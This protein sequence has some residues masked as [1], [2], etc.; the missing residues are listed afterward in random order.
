M[1]SFVSWDKPEAHQE[2]DQ[3]KLLINPQTKMLEY[4]MYTIRETYLNMPGA[5]AFF[6]SI[7]FSDFK[8]INGVLIPFTQTI[9]LNKPKK[10]KKNIHQFKVSDFQFDA[11]DAEI[12]KPFPKVKETG[13]SKLKG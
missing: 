8:D 2:H 13:D 9:F 3:Y 7:K 6:G 12:L 1:M 11:V 4:A 5:Q 10:E